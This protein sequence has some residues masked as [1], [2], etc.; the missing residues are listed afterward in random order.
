MAVVAKG[1]RINEFDLPAAKRES[2]AKLFRQFR[3]EE[4]IVLA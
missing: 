4:V 2:L 3:T 1:G